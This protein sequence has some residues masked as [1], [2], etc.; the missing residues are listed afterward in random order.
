M[1]K[2]APKTMSTIDPA[3]A[4][5]QFEFRARFCET[6][7]MGIVHHGNYFQYF[8]MGRVDWLRKRGVTYAEWAAR[9]THLPV[10]EVRS[11]YRAPARF[12][13]LLV[14]TTTLVELRSHSLRFAYLLHRDKTLLA[15]GETRLACIDANQKLIPFT[16][17]LRAVL[18]SAETRAE[19]A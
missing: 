17:E 7:L 16:G 8:E 12:D 18:T 2:E 3:A 15:E 19:I 6:D 13:D 5:S 9:G 1:T 14:V 11:R 4:Q 10:V